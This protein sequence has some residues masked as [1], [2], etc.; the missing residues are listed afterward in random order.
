LFVT[1]TTGFCVAL[2]V[3]DPPEPPKPA[4]PELPAGKLMV[5]GQGLGVQS[6]PSP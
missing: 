5:T 6:V 2:L 3:G 1:T 4:A